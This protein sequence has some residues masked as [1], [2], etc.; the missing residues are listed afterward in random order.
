MMKCKPSYPAVLSVFVLTLGACSPA[1]ADES[2]GTDSES[3]GEPADTGDAVC[4]LMGG[5]SLSI[6][7]PPPCT[8]DDFDGFFLVSETT[9][10]AVMVTPCLTADC[11]ECANSIPAPLKI[12]PVPLAGV[13]S[14]G[15]CLRVLAN[16]AP[17]TNPDSCVYENIVVLQLDGDTELA[18]VV[19]PS[20]SEVGLPVDVGFLPF[21]NPREW[22]SCYDFPDSCCETRDQ[23]YPIVYDY[24][25]GDQTVS[26]GESAAIGMVNGRTY[27]FFAFDA[28]MSGECGDPIHLAWALVAQ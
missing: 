11:A 1:G 21:I 8:G 17:T 28:F 19:A 6:E 14:P 23:V 9:D 12:S 22:C 4:E 15:T 10:D 26:V 27:E 2:D 20:S 13:A 7:L 18:I 3:S 24:H 25:I 5:T 16:R